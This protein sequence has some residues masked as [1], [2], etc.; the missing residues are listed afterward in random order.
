[1]AAPPCHCSLPTQPALPINPHSTR[2]PIPTHR[3]RVLSLAF[4]RR[5][6]AVPNRR[7]GPASE[8][9]HSKRLM[10]CIMQIL[11]GSP[12][13]LLRSAAT[14]LYSPHFHRVARGRRCCAVEYGYAAASEQRASWRRGP[15]Y[16]VK[17]RR[18]AREAVKGHSDKKPAATGEDAEKNVFVTVANTAGCNR[19]TDGQQSYPYLPGTVHLSTTPI[20]RE[21]S[22]R[23]RCDD[24]QLAEHS[25]YTMSR[26]RPALG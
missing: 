8:N 17:R 11:T 9:L 14:S 22:R 6:P 1:M 21:T 16:L 20:P 10:H 3:S 18:S 25:Q 19:Y 13:R 23:L 4:R 24:V 2:G 5:P 15:H 12:R 26:F 7:H